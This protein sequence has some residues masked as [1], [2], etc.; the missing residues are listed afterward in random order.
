[1]NNFKEDIINSAKDI[2][3]VDFKAKIKFAGTEFYVL[4]NF[5]YQDVKYYYI[6]EAKESE[7]E[8]AGGFERYQ[9]KIRM[10]Y[11]F[12]DEPG[13]YQT[14]IDEKLLKELDA[15]QSLRILEGKI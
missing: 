1:M 9:G 15:I 14:V 10:E 8:Q 5:V 6:I 3:P 4:D 11:I 2:P 13:I 12:E 7:I